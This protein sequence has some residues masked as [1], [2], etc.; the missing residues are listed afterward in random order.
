MNPDA[1]ALLRADSLAATLTAARA[2]RVRRRTSAVVLTTLALGAV[3]FFVLPRHPPGPAFIA[4]ARPAAPVASSSVP[5]AFARISTRE[6]S[7][8][9]RFS[10]APSSRVERIDTAGLSRCFPDKGIA[11]IQPEGEPA[12]VVFF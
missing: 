8:L 2:R 5:P 4:T 6:S 1:L 11:V 7:P 9:V 3:I 12:K 10:T